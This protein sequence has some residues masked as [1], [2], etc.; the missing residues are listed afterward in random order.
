[1]R[2]LDRG[3]GAPGSPGDSAKIN[4]TAT[5]LPRT[6]GIHPFSS[7]HAGAQSSRKRDFLER[8]G[9]SHPAES[10]SIYWRKQSKFIFDIIEIYLFD[11]R[12]YDFLLI[13]FHLKLVL[14]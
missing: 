14:L 3:C 6:P 13:S 8:G 4:L 12:L 1:M 9:R 2:R 7:A 10:G 5:R 11:Q